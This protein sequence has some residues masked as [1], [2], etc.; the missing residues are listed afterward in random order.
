MLAAH[1]MPLLPV[2]NRMAL[3]YKSQYA[4]HDCIGAKPWH[5]VLTL[6]IHTAQQATHRMVV[7]FTLFIKMGSVP[8]VERHT[9]RAHIDI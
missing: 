8:F 1:T 6:C 2:L 4:V 7:L 5:L 3:E 9:G